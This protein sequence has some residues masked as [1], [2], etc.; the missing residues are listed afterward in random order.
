[1]T[2]KNHA[3]DETILSIHRLPEGLLALF[4]LFILGW[5]AH[6]RV[7]IILLVP[8]SIVL[9]A[10]IHIVRPYRPYTQIGLAFGYVIGAGVTAILI[11]GI[12]TAPIGGDPEG[13]KAFYRV[14]RPMVLLY[15]IS[16]IALVVKVRPTRQSS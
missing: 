3:K 9:L 2:P 11:F 16:L 5:M 15:G 6:Q 10:G 13:T 14:A 4:G 7:G 12:L 8:G 1:M